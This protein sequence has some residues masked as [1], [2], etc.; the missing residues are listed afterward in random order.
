MKY[1]QDLYRILVGVRV[2]TRNS[3]ELYSRPCPNTTSS[4]KPAID[5]PHVLIFCMHS[6]CSFAPLAA[7][8][9]TH[10]AAGH[11]LSAASCA[12]AIAAASSVAAAIS[13]AVI[14]TT[15]LYITSATTFCYY[16]PLCFW[17][18]WALLPPVPLPPRAGCGPP[19]PLG[20]R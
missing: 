9:T 3:T 10:C 2:L 1:L 18:L 14:T 7:L 17:E 8:V 4:V 16:C 13:A 5:S 12:A 20:H 11:P 19:K 6:S 15:S